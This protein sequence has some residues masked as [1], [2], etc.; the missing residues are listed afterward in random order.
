MERREFIQ[1]SGLLVGGAL[2]GAATKTFVGGRYPDVLDVNDERTHG[3]RVDVTIGGVPLYAPVRADRRKGVAWVYG[4]HPNGE[5]I[6][7][8][9]PGAVTERYPGSLLFS[10]RG[11]I[12]FR[13]W[14]PGT[15]WEENRD[16]HFALFPQHVLQGFDREE[17][18]GWDPAPSVYW[19]IESD[20]LLYAELLKRRLESRA[21]GRQPRKSTNLLRDR[22]VPKFHA[23][24]K[25]HFGDK[26]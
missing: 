20:L 26:T 9:I 18:Q 7:D 2:A 6:H 12:E 8:S 17:W 25:I 24:W 22:E 14:K 4:Y 13:P 19:P 21:Q 16:R 3:L 10:L 1:T 15:T 23:D 11:E 5:M